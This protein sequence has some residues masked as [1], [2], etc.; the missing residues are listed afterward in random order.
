MTEEGNSAT[1]SQDTEH[2]LM[3]TFETAGYD[4]VV[5]TGKAPRPVYL[6]ITEHSVELCDAGSLWGKDTYDTVFA[7]R[8]E[9]EP[10]SI[11]AIG[12]AGE[13][14]VNTSV[15][16]TDTGQ[17]AMGQGGMPAVMGSKKLKAIVA[18]QGATPIR[19]AYPRRLQRATDGVLERIRSYPRL[20]GLREGGGWY[21]LRG[22]MLGG[23]PPDQEAIEREAE[24]FERHKRSR[25]NIAC[26]NCPVACRERIDLREGEYAGL[27]S[28][29][30][31]TTGGGLNAA[32]ARLGHVQDAVGFIHQDLALVAGVAGRKRTR[33]QIDPR[34]HVVF[35]LDEQQLSLRRQR[36]DRTPPARMIHRK[37]KDTID[38]EA[39][40]IHHE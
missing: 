38:L 29:N 1:R 16:H 7:L 24:A 33:P 17:G 26:P 27:L 8:S 12:P 4:H 32:G 23:G 20:S 10:C 25:S 40:C 15:T 14:L 36:H 6:K 9:Y 37:V 18:L 30:T 28:Y 21:M 19:V 34:E 39:V 3:Q 5:I 11:I 35:P 2:V 13:N 22:G 31:M